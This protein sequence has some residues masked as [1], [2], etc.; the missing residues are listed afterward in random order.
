[1]A[2][3]CRPLFL[4]VINSKGGPGKSTL[5]ANLAGLCADAGLRTLG[6]DIETQPTYSCY[7]RAKPRAGD[8]NVSS[9]RAGN[10]HPDPKGGLPTDWDQRAAQPLWLGAENAPTSPSGE[11]ESA[12]TPDRSTD[13]L[14]CR[15]ANTT[16]SRTGSRRCHATAID[17]LPPRAGPSVAGTDECPGKPTH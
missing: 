1:M 15:T 9:G 13:R 4:S 14:P 6:L 3:L 7:F 11:L 2:A 17:R 5:S 12:C 10:R 16:G 8:Q